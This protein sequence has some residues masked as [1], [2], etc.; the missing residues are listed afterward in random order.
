MNIKNKQWHLI[1]SVAIATLGVA[2]FLGI[3]SLAPSAQVQAS[4]MTQFLESA[5]SEEV[6]FLPGVTN[7]SKNI[8]VNVFVGGGE[9]SA[10]GGL[11]LGPYRRVGH[12]LI[13][14][15]DIG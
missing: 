8:S 1:G 12:G 14:G 6:L 4:S 13:A 15:V 10:P 11:E 9:G 5:A 7:Q 2:I 3:L